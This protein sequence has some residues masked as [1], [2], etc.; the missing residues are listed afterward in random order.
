MHDNRIDLTVR[1]RGEVI[2]LLNARLA[3]AIDLQT[4]A[5]HAHWN[6]K[7]PTFIALHELFD[8]LAEN[9]EEHIDRITERVTSLGGTAEGALASVAKATALAPCPAGITEGLAHSMRCRPPSRRSDATSARRLTALMRRATRSR[10]I[11]SLR[12]QARSTNTFWFLEAHLQA[13]H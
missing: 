8:E 10:P 7:G 13:K 2:S 1:V 12:S 5:K 6:V 9:V 11:S 3:D 4:Q